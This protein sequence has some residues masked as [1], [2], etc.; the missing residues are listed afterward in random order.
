MS[1]SLSVASRVTP[2]SSPEDDRQFRVVQLSNG[3]RVLLVSDAAAN[4]AAASV[5]VNVGS[6]HNPQRLQG[7]A[8]YL[9]HM[10]FLGTA[11]FP[12]EDTYSKTLA[13]HG[14]RSNAYTAHEHTCYYFDVVPDKLNVML[15][16]FSQFFIA[17]LFTE[18]ASE[19]ELN[20][21]NSEHNKN[22]QSDTWRVWRLRL[23]RGFAD[24]PQSWFHTG[25]FASLRD[26]PLAAGIDLRAELIA[27]HR[28]FYSAAGM[29][30]CVVGRESLDELEQTVATL[31]APIATH[32]T[33]VPTHP[34]LTGVSVVEQCRAL[35][36]SD[37]RQFPLAA[38]VGEWLECDAVRDQRSLTISWVLPSDAESYEHGNMHY[39]SNLIGHEGA[40]SILAILKSQQLA[41]AL[42]AGPSI[43]SHAY[44]LFDVTIELTEVGL[45]EAER[46]VA[47]VC[48]YVRLLRKH[49][50]DERV[51]N[52]LRDLGLM[53]FRFA[54]KPDPISFAS[55]MSM[56]LQETRDADVLIASHLQRRFDAAAIDK[57]LACM[58]PESVRV[59]VSAQRDDGETA[60]WTTE[61]IYGTK[62]RAAP[63]SAAQL[64]LFRRDIVSHALHLPHA[65]PFVPNA[66]DL[67]PLPAWDEA[68]RVAA[69]PLPPAP[70]LLH[71]SGR[72][73]VWHLQ[74]SQFK[75]PK[76]NV[77]LR[78][79]TPWPN[80]SPRNSM[81]MTLLLDVVV[82]G[83][84]ER[85]YDAQL[86]ELHFQLSRTAQG[87][88]VSLGGFTDK[89]P[90]LFDMVLTALTTVPL[91]TARF[92]ALKEKVRQTFANI[93]FRDPY[94][95]ASYWRD[96]F[97]L[98]A[99]FSFEEQLTALAVLELPDLQAYATTVFCGARA[100]LFAHGNISAQTAATLAADAA[101][102]CF[103]DAAVPP[104]PYHV[105]LRLGRSVALP[106]GSHIR[107]MQAHDDDNVNSAIVNVYQIDGILTPRD[108]AIG[109]VINAI[110]SDAAFTQLR[111]QEQLGYIVYFQHTRDESDASFRCVVQ[112]SE[113]PV[114]LNWRIERYVQKQ[115][116][117]H[118]RDMADEE[119]AKYREAL[120][121]EREQ[122]EK[123]LNEVTNRFWNEIDNSRLQ[124]R[125]KEDSVATIRSVTRADVVAFFT[126]HVADPLT[127]RKFSLQ[128]FSAAHFAATLRSHTDDRPLLHIAARSD[129]DVA[130]ARADGLSV[131]AD[132]LI[133]TS[134]LEG[135]RVVRVGADWNLFKARNM[136]TAVDLGDVTSAQFQAPAEAKAVVHEQLKNW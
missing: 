62:F 51:Y 56:A 17:P 20:A 68:R 84:N 81:L 63:L 102:K 124:F 24:H 7:L 94:R 18:S 6:V 106:V 76:G 30:A 48:E 36:T 2:I 52:E 118:L 61:A 38:D 42:S 87:I 113:N 67:L 134:A 127:R 116:L 77:L 71:H 1:T 4:T 15:D 64:E 89:L 70:L 57:L 109:D 80:T 27:F 33:P 25:N 3:L 125:R 110:L 121:V 74:D 19:R 29:T 66:F 40:G 31:F 119:F 11:K 126:R 86:A 43:T 10:L 97:S 37:W 46:V 82:D 59:T 132:K 96:A 115:A 79:E 78:V 117:A 101:R 135:A 103:G 112:S 122:P 26:E 12:D 41:N 100:T 21:V 131:D 32:A 107:Q 91:T 5:T 16:I 123:R 39:L 28:R 60:D 95:L 50:A 105:G 133:D 73:S 75:K 45:A 55:R 53:A 90:A 136:F 111:T 104:L 108:A 129:S 23:S 58:T 49:G 9:E 14:G 54:S 85:T 35:P 44:Q 114:L 92:A 98:S 130:D 69:A 120:A 65:N 47:I 128:F 72:L 88:N 13:S 34:A 93:P 99:F 83:L 22:L 8:H